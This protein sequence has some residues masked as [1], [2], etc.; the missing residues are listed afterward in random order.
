[1]W[2]VYENILNI[3]FIPTVRNICITL[4]SVYSYLDLSCPCA[5]TPGNAILNFI[6]MCNQL[7][8][9]ASLPLHPLVR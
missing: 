7:H 3:V 5:Q 2:P 1:M 4:F 8:S 6:M 9:L